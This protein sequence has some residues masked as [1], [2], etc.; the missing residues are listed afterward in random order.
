MAV[1]KK[2]NCNIVVTAGIGGIGD[3]KTEKLSYDLPALSKM[4]ITL[5]ATSPKDMLDIPGTFDYLHENG[6]N[7]YGYNR[8]DCNGYIFVLEPV[9]LKKRISEADLSNIPAGCNLH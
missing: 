7:T 5:V 3:I 1:A 2:I 6:V 9:K 8:Q 4:G